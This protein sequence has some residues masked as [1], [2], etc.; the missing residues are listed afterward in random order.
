MH[1]FGRHLGVAFQIA[2]DLKDL[3]GSEPGKPQFADLRSR[4]PSLP[5]VLAAAADEALRRRLKDAWAFGSIPEERVRAVN[6]DYLDPAE[7][8]PD[9]WA[10]DPDTLVI[11]R[12]GEDLFRLR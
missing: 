12:A 1:A 4:T 3:S 8:D 7:V 10:A 6:V 5:I 9:A 2:D 11:P